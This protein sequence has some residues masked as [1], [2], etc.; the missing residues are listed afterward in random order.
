MLAELERLVSR[1]VPSAPT[2]QEIEGAQ[3]H[4]ETAMHLEVQRTTLSS[5]KPLFY[6]WRSL[7]PTLSSLK[8]CREGKA[9]ESLPTPMRDYLLY[10]WYS[11]QLIE[12]CVPVT[13]QSA[14]P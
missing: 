4:D 3:G 13:K 6:D 8:S 14:S 7:A 2:E 10:A 12:Q 1:P 11:I 9:I 5:M